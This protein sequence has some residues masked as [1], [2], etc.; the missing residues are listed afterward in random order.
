VSAPLTALARAQALGLREAASAC[1][2]SQAPLKARLLA[3]ADSLHNLA[4]M[5]ERGAQASKTAGSAKNDIGGEI[6]RLQKIEALL[7]CIHHAANEEIEVDVS[8]A[9]A[10]ACERIAE[11]LEGLDRLELAL[12]SKGAEL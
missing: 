11:S 1:N 10:V 5:A 6:R 3:A 9:L 12:G 7:I 8:D 4:L 2:G